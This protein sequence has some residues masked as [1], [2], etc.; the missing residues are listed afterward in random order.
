MQPEAAKSLLH[1]Y[2]YYTRCIVS[3]DLLIQKV[4]KN[5]S[6]IGQHSPPI[7]EDWDTALD[8][9]DACVESPH[10]RLRCILA[11]LHIDM[12]WYLWLDLFFVFRSVLIACADRSPKITTRFAKG[13]QAGKKAPSYVSPHSQIKEASTHVQDPQSYCNAVRKHD[14]GVR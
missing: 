3:R 10:Q 9:S 4:E 2:Y 12:M 8:L 7:C 6:Y 11:G 5:I 1:I 13:H 14:M